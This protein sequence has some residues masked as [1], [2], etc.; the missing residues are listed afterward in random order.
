M[1]CMF[2]REKCNKEIKN[3]EWR[4]QIRSEGHLKREGG[5]FCS[6][7]KTSYTTLKKWYF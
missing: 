6:F 7:Y 5:T 1:K 4:E 3:D 2:F